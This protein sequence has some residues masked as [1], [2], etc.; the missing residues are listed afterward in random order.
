MLF[1]SESVTKTADGYRMVNNDPILWT[2]L[3]AIKE[4]QTQIAAQQNQIELLT[5][6]VCSMN[7]KSD[8]CP[9]K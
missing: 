3:N 2:M 6:A 7:P 8:I 1:R 5:M 4:Q 9:K